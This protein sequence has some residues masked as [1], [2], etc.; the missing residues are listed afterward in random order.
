LIIRWSPGA[1][2]QMTG[3]AEFVFTGTYLLDPTSIAG[4]P[5]V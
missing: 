1:E 4:R 3:P 5:A 2:I